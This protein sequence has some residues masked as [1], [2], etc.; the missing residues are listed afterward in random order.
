MTA[1]GSES[2][3]PLGLLQ[4]IVRRAVW[5]CA[6]ESTFLV[7]RAILSIRLHDKAQ[8]QR[9]DTVLASK[10]HL[11]TD[12]LTRALDG[13]GL[14]LRVLQPLARLSILRYELH[15]RLLQLAHFRE[16]LRD[17][18]KIAGGRSRGFIG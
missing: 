1:D 11:V 6:A 17:D 5:Y 7:L 4:H 10:A 14:L 18:G 8:L 12:E 16:E 15:V 3:S 2:D 13:L 9:P